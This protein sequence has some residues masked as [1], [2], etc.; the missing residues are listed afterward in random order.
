M[1][2]PCN[3]AGDDGAGRGRVGGL[4]ARMLALVVA[5][6]GLVRVAVVAGAGLVGRARALLAQPV[7]QPPHR[8]HRQYVTEPPARRCAPH[9]W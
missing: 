6:G 2:S 8:P 9:I 5:L 1:A 3:T 4:C 7:A